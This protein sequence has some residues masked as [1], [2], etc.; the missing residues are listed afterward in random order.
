VAQFRFGHR[1]RPSPVRR[2]AR[3]AIVPNLAARFGKISH[4]S[5][6]YIKTKYFVWNLILH[7]T[8]IFRLSVRIR[9]TACKWKWKITTLKV[10]L[11][12]FYPKEY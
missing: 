4:S 6:K 8:N 7:T 5:K 3:R 12:V 11:F 2:R 10:L 1:A 9:L